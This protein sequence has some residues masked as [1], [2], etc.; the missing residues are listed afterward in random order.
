VQPADIRSPIVH[1]VIEVTAAPMTHGHVSVHPDVQVS[2][3]A[4]YSPVVKPVIDVMSH[5]EPA[6]IVKPVVIVN[7]DHSHPILEQPTMHVISKQGQHVEVVH[8]LINIYNDEG[9]QH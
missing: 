2:P 7:P 3:G 8:P 1:P 9:H 5:N 6:A 4:E